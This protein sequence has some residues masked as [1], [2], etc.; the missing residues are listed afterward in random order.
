MELEEHA[1]P[2]RPLT[3]ERFLVPTRR[4]EPHEAGWKV[5]EGDAVLTDDLQRRRRTK[6]DRLLPFLGHVVA[7]TDVCQRAL[8]RLAVAGEIEAQHLV[9]VRGRAG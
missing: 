6:P 9:V 3:V 1:L 2:D 5:D 8:T 4:V 7:T